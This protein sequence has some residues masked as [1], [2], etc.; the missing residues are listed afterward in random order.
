MNCQ[1]VE[2]AITD[3]ARGVDIDQ[4]V[5]DHVRDCGGCAERLAEQR[6]LTAALRA[7]SDE[8]VAE[9]APVAMEEALLKAFRRGAVPARRGR[10]WVPV[11]VA[12]S[13]AAVALLAQWLRPATPVAVDRLAPLTPPA[14]TVSAAS[15]PVVVVS[16]PAPRRAK[17]RPAR[18]VN[19]APVKTEVEF[20]AVA[21][22]DAWTPLDG[23][24]LV[25]V[26]LPRSAMRGFGLPV[27]EER[28]YEQVQADVM[29]SNDGLLR[30]IRFIP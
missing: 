1:D 18:G 16:P 12:A 4:A 28:S 27:N 24:R 22:G 15:A 30:A 6:K 9:Q 14:Q 10:V 3:L 7:W 25:R 29:L 8:T 11:A 21:Q 17:T 19:P 26:Q 13:I 23:G 20:V 5:S 2:K